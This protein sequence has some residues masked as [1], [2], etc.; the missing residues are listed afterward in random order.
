MSRLSKQEL[1]QIESENV[2]Y[3]NISLRRIYRK[4]FLEGVETYCFYQFEYSLLKMIDRYIQ[5]HPNKTAEKG[6]KAGLN[7]AYEAWR[8]EEKPLPQNVVKL[9]KDD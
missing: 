6:F 3:T 1:W 5:A 2:P 8:Q 9:F 7:A 4:A